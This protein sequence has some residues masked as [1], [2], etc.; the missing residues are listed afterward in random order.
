VSFRGKKILLSG[1]PILFPNLK[2]LEL[3]SETGSDICADTFC[4]AYGRMY[5]P[6]VIDEETDEGIIRA[7]T[8][9]YVSASLCPCFLSL[10]KFLDRI[11][12]LT[13]E[14]K[15]D[16]VIYHN[17]RLCSVFDIQM[18]FVRYALREEGIP[19]LFIKTDL[20]REDIGQLKTRIEAFIEMLG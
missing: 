12:D 7:L 3:V 4:S 9:K 18:P 15:I 19:V 16:G 8:L 17:L 5:D 20:S 10:D 6:V 2:L 1:S 14:H 11:I 13:K